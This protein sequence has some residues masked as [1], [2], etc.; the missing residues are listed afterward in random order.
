[1][2]APFPAVRSMSAAGGPPG[3]AA[4]D[5]PA[6]DIGAELVAAAADLAA[7]REVRKC[8]V[9][10]EQALV[11]G[12]PT[13][14][15]ED[16]A[17]A[18]AAIVAAGQRVARAVAAVRGLKSRLCN[19]ECEPVDSRGAV[20]EASPPRH[21][22]KRPASLAGLGRTVGTPKL[23]WLNWD[24]SIAIELASRALG[25]A[26]DLEPAWAVADAITA[27]MGECSEA[28]QASPACT[29]DP[30]TVHRRLAAA[31]VPATL[32]IARINER[33]QGLLIEYEYGPD[34]AREY[35]ADCPV[36]SP[37]AER[38]LRRAR[39]AAAEWNV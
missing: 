27:L 30:G 6:K 34:V 13:V 4:A 3:G 9:A 8:A 14:A 23:G 12:L 16:R 17:A 5:A 15:V 38:R 19:L 22:G 24:G 32:S 1:M 37:E 2:L 26:G 33:A 11:A 36:V 7:A 18:E 28:M 31:L 35:L 20:L 10:A 29:L 39:A 25:F 21:R